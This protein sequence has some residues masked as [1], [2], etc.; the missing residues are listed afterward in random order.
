MKPKSMILV[1]T[2]AIIGVSMALK[3]SLI[4]GPLCFN[5]V[6]YAIEK[7]PDCLRAFLYVNRRQGAS[8]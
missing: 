3:G 8:D 1:I 4:A 5:F 7:L 6:V 2:L